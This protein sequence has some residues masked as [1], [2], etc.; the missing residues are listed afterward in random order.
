MIGQSGQN[1]VLWCSLW[2]LWSVLHFSAVRSASWLCCA[3]CVCI[4]VNSCAVRFAGLP[5]FQGGFAVRWSAL[6][7]CAV[8]CCA[9]E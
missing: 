1:T 4:P 7:C 3:M 6:L 9:L 5:C 8:P 2:T